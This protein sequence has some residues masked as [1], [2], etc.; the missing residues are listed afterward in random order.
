MPYSHLQIALLQQ[1]EM[2][3]LALKNDPSSRKRCTL[4]RRRKDVI[5]FEMLGDQLILVKLKGDY[6]EHYWTLLDTKGNI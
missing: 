1:G 4:D 2:Y 3:A 6:N 5:F